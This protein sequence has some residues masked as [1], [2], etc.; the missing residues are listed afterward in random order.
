MI[1]FIVA[2]NGS[3]A[4][5]PR[6][7][8]HRVFEICSSLVFASPEAVDVLPRGIPSDQGDLVRRDADDFTVLSVPF[9]DTVV[10]PARDEVQS[11]ADPGCSAQLGAWDVAERM[12]VDVVDSN[13]QYVASGL[14]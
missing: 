3:G 2:N 14:Q 1:L 11:I 10:H 13:C 12:E 9:G 7:V 5:C 4:I 8:P 6:W